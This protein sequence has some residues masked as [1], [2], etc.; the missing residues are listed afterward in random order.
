MGGMNVSKISVLH[1]VGPTHGGIKQ[2]VKTLI[3]NIDKSTFSSLIACDFAKGDLE[4]L[5]HNKIKYFPIKVVNSSF[6]PAIPGTVFALKNIINS[7]S[8]DIIHSH[9]LKATF[10]AITAVNISKKSIPVIYT[11]HSDIP[12]QDDEKVY[13]LFYKGMEKILMDGAKKI[14][15][16][17]NTLKAQ[18]IARVPKVKEKIITIYGG[19]ALSRVEPK[20]LKS[21]ESLKKK[22]NIN[23]NRTKIIGTAARLAP[24]KGLDYLIKAMGQ[25]IQKHPDAVL[26]IAG[27]GPEKEKL[28]K[29]AASE[30]ISGHVH[31][32]GYLEDIGSFYHI[33]DIFAL[34]SLTEG[35]SLALIEVLMAKRAVVASSVGG[36][37]EVIKN[38]HT[39]LLVP[40]ADSSLLAKAINTLLENEDLRNSLKNNGKQYAL[41]N[42]GMDNMITQY[43]KLYENTL[44][45]DSLS[46]SRNKL[47]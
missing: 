7:H 40:S 22:L 6:T 25:V 2:Y 19:V 45:K 47:D 29:L 38:N 10:L 18:I 26:I 12:F 5:G 27:E 30:G 24:Q 8:I 1:V 14:V 28:L 20:S 16:V 35:L 15:T 17:S 43:A 33:I 41:D 23:N 13:S 3:F 4:E 46:I 32:L 34:P 37:G 9:G 21:I 39:G 44:S 42:F 31:F 11:A 36:I